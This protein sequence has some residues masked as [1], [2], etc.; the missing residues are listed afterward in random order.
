MI[1][2]IKRAIASTKSRV[3]LCQTCS[4]HKSD[5]AFQ[6]LHRQSELTVKEPF[7]IAMSK[8]GGRTVLDV[9]GLGGSFVP[10]EADDDETSTSETETGGEKPKVKS[11]RLV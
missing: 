11:V 5:S 9:V 4:G 1:C 8:E 3:S 6:G 10:A 7:R 2:S